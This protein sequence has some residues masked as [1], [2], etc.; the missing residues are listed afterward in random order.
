MYRTECLYD[1][2]SDQCRKD[3][4][5]RSVRFLPEEDDSLV[6]IVASLRALP[7]SDAICLLHSLRSNDDNEAVAA[8]IPT[9]VC[10]PHSCDPT[11]LGSEFVQHAFHSDS[12][13]TQPHARSSDLSLSLSHDRLSG[14]NLPSDGK[15]P[16]QNPSFFFGT[17]KDPEFVGHLLELY[18]TWVHPFHQLFSQDLFST[19]FK[20]GATGHCSALL[21][22]AIAAFACHYSD[23]IAAR[24]DP[25]DMNTAG[26]HFFNEAKRLLDLRGEPSLT[27]VQALGIMGF[28]ET[29][30][31]RC[32]D[33]YQYTG[34]CLRAA[35][36]MDLHLPVVGG[37]PCSTEHEARK[38]TF[39]G[40]FNAET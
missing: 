1:L 37:S 5:Q 23:R 40:V 3:A 32:S 11:S 13:G 35:L 14:G 9:G 24:A 20:H 15:F 4:L 25:N 2:D 18:F 36:E 26:D 34:R 28:R 7:E 8:L 22:N 21:V 33:G 10:L 31:G 38:I 6:S 30:R 27:T 19:D 16:Y 29:S 39:W 12:R 17:P